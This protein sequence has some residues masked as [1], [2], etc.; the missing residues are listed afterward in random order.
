MGTSSRIRLAGLV[1]AL[2]AGLALVGRRPRWERLAI[3]AS[4]PVIV[5]AVN[6]ARLTAAGLFH[7][8]D[9]PAAAS[10]VLRDPG[11]AGMI[12][13]ALVVLALEYCVLGR[14]Y[15]E[16][17]GGEPPLLDVGAAP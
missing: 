15:R 12:C 11:S 4:G 16:V 1:V 7:A 2:A 8:W 5:L 3:F 9:R 14:L 13:L 10:I 6:I 17:P